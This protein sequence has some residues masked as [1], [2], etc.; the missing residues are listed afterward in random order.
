MKLASADGKC[1]VILRAQVDSLSSVLT[2][3]TEHHSALDVLDN[4][5]QLFFGIHV[6]GLAWL[7]CSQLKG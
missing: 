7:Y 5:L 1:V 3:S 2:R 6:E 4:I